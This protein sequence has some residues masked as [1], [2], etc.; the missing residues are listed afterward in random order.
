[1]TTDSSERAVDAPAVILVVDDT[2]ASRYIASSWLRRHGH[3]VMEAATGAEALAALA[4]WPVDLVVLDVGL[5]DMSGFEVCEQ[6]KSDPALSQPVIHLSAT[7]VRGAD[8][9]QG[10]TRGA[11]AYL[12]E[13]VEPDEL[14]ATVASVLRYYRARASAEELADRLTRLTRATLAM[15]AA[16]SFDQLASAIAAGAADILGVPALA[17]VTAPDGALRRA[18]ADPAVRADPVRDIAPARLLHD[19]AAQPT[20]STRS[21]EALRVPWRLA[22]PDTTEDAEGRAALFGSRGGPPLGIVLRARTLRDESSDLLAQLGHA[23]VLA[24]DSLRL[25]TEEHTLA[26]TLQRSF[27]P[28]PPAEL[29]GLEIAVRYVPAARN[30]EIGGD[31]Y[32]FVELE[33]GRLLVA[34]GDVSG[35]SIHAATVMVELR[36]ALRAYAVEGHGPAEILN[37]LERMLRQYHPVEFATLCVLVLDPDRNELA[38]ANAGHLPPL[39]VERA[40]AGYVQVRGPMLGLRRRQPPDTVLQLPPSWSIVLITDGLVEDHG[41]DLDDALEELRAAAAI[42]TS[43]EELCGQLL[44]RFGRTGLDDI[45]LLALRRRS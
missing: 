14:L 26:L 12:V 24:A 39:L 18:T 11:D 37:R 30:A 41:V 19:L 40:G 22:A 25:Y 16:T 6:I 13:P 2:A 36:H 5:P 34:I 7:A 28:S 15:N 29:P 20:D 8:R 44:E 17:L 23:A 9:A 43:P 42:D 33:G 10:L 45:A 35:H 32:E 31:F 27:L 3:R 38:V 1:M 21:I 4:R